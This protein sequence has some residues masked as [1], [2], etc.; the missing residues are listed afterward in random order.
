MFRPQIYIRRP[1]SALVD[2]EKKDLKRVRVFSDR[3]KILALVVN[4][5]FDSAFR[6]APRLVREFVIAELNGILTRVPVDYRVFDKD[7][8]GK[9]KKTILPRCWLKPISAGSVL[10]WCVSTV[11]THRV[12]I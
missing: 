5:F 12:R 6:S 7:R 1:P 4:L 9:T 11:G 8:D 2:V 10:H 3:V